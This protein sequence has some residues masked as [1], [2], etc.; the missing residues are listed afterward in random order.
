MNSLHTVKK[1]PGGMIVIPLL[2]GAFINTFWPH[3]FA[4]GGF[5]E[6]LF[7]TGATALLGAFLFWSCAQINL[8]EAG[9]SLYKGLVLL[10]CK[11]LIAALANS[12]GGFYAALASEIGESTDV[13]LTS[14]IVTALLCPLLVSLLDRREKPK[15][16]KEVMFHD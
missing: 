16:Q 10:V 5:T 1:I 2:L 11:V 13:G 6:T 8:R 3:F 12:N 7:K 4:S 9:T 14:I 15:D